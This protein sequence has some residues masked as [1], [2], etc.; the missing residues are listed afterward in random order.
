MT[1]PDHLIFVNYRGTDEIWATEFVYARMTEAF[2]AETVFKA[3][4]ALNPGEIFSPVLLEKAATCPVML[5]CVGPAWLRAQSAD[6]R[7]RLD[8]P[9]DYVRREIATSIRADNWVI[10][11]LLGDQ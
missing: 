7:R 9:D 3:G 8:S 1:H 2:G 4:N 6:G 10:P 11:L 5:A